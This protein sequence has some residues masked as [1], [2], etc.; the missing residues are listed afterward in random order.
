MLCVWGSLRF[1]YCR[2]PD[3][4]P[5]QRVRAGLMYGY[6]VLNDPDLSPNCLAYSNG[7]ILIHATSSLAAPFFAIAI[8]C[9]A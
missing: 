9:R 4:V 5:C 1:R 2:R 3:D 6:R 8:P 7:P